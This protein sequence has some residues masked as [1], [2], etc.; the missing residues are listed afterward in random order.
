MGQCI[1][2]KERN[3]YYCILLVW[4]LMNCYGHLT[5]CRKQEGGGGGGGVCVWGGGRGRGG[6]G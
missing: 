2:I 5:K 1:K 6:G 4:V 3:N